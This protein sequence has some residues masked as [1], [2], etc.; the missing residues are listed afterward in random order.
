M[1]YR[2]D[3]TSSGIAVAAAAASA[4]FPDVSVVT[5]YGT[6]PLPVVMT[7]IAGAETG[8]TFAANAAGDPLSIYADGGASEAAYSCGGLTSFGLWQIN[9]PSHAGALATLSG[10]VASNPCGQAAWLYTPANCAAAALA[11]YQSQGLGA[12]TTFNEGTYSG[13]LQPAQQAVAAQGATQPLL[14]TPVAVGGGA[15]LLGLL[16]VG[17]GVEEERAA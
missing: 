12:W 8:G 5:P 3:A 14:S 17:F 1:I 9:L 11:V 7:A 4:A 2:A 15:I 6:Y 16:L 13:W 10:V